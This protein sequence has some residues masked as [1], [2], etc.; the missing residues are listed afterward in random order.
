LVSARPGT[1]YAGIRTES[2]IY[3]RG[4][5]ALA[6]GMGIR[7]TG[8]LLDVD[9]ETVNHWLPVLGRPWQG[10]MHDCFRHLPL[11]ECQLDELW[12]CVAKKEDH[13][14]PLEQLAPVYG[15]AWVGSAFSPV[16]QLVPAWGVG[17]R[18]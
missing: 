5:V 3:L 17:K 11:R 4:A 16:C 6:E 18:T 14:T 1:A 12:T 13:L 2:T 15:D 8:R 10:V 9:K 7:A